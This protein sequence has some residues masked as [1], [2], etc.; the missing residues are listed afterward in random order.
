LAVRMNTIN[1]VGRSESEFP[2]ILD[3]SDSL[4]RTFSKLVADGKL[5][6][7]YHHCH[8]GARGGAGAGAG[9]ATALAPLSEMKETPFI[10]GD[11]RVTKYSNIKNYDF[12]RKRSTKRCWIRFVPKHRRIVQ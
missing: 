12:T 10:V 3:G 7:Q 6:A 5:C 1:V 11:E 4:P 2:L 9:A 8:Q